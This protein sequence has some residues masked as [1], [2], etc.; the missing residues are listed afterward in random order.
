MMKKMIKH[1]NNNPNLEEEERDWSHIPGQFLWG[2]MN[3]LPP[4]DAMRISYVCNSWKSIIK[5]EPNK[6]T[7]PWVLCNPSSSIS[8]DRI[9]IDLSTNA[10]SRVK[11]PDIVSQGTCISSKHGWLL[12]H[13]NSHPMNIIN[14]GFYSHRIFPYQPRVTSSKYE[15][16]TSIVNNKCTLRLLHPVSGTVIDLP[17][18]QEE[19]CN[20][21][22]GPA[23]IGAVSELTG[24][25]ELIIQAS[26][27][28]HKG[29]VLRITRAGQ[30]QWEEHRFQH[31]FGWETRVARVAMHGSTR[32]CCFDPKGRMC[33]FEMEDKSWLIFPELCNSR[34]GFVVECEDEV[35]K[36]A[37]LPPSVHGNQERYMFYKLGLDENGVIGWVEMERVGL[38]NKW[39]FLD[40]NGESYCVKGVGRKVFQL[41][42]H[43]GMVRNG[44]GRVRFGTRIVS[45]VGI[46]LSVLDLDDGV[47]QELMPELALK[48]CKLG[49]ILMD[50]P[51]S[52]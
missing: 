4:F 17:E 33:V 9:F 16:N 23:I 8:T 37:P 50:F 20:V 1:P 3:Y 15:P 51:V 11:I 43:Y 21:V 45:E 48:D 24:K 49:W 19:D 40:I 38:E 14:G 52:V 46:P 12:L 42:G 18:I 10:I 30:S 34:S 6:I 35:V 27:R 47:P 39:W 31:C 41:F 29:I 32:V 28:G 5:P 25:P 26:F 2:V 22:V 44:G 13:P 7:I 36:V